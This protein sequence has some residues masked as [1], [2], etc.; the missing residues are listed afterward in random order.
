MCCEGDDKRCHIRPGKRFVSGYNPACLIG[1]KAGRKTPVLDPYAGT[2]SPRWPKRRNQQIKITRR[3]AC[4]FA[5]PELVRTQLVKNKLVIAGAG[6]DDVIAATRRE[7]I[8]I[9]TQTTIKRIVAQPTIECVITSTTI[10]TASRINRCSGGCAG[11]VGKGQCGT[12]IAIPAEQRIVAI[13]SFE[14]VD[15]ASANQVVVAPPSKAHII[16]H[17][18]KPIGSAGC[19]TTEGEHI[20]AFSGGQAFDRTCRIG[21]NA[22]RK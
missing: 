5:E 13:A 6:G 9:T 10:K 3:G 12:I 17:R 20:I 4:H 14:P 2:Q 16:N 15:P 22:A 1:W 19:N 11:V 8:T 21:D 7:K 18:A